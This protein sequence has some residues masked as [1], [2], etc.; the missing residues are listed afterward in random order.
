MSYS[1][2]YTSEMI[3]K[4]NLKKLHVIHRLDNQSTIFDLEFLNKTQCS[5]AKHM[6]ESKKTTNAKNEASLVK[7]YLKALRRALNYIK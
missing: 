5:E 3:E 7:N 2:K 6:I 4:L 1:F